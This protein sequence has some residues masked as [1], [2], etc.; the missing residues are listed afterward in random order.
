MDEENLDILDK[1]PFLSYI[2]YN[3]DSYLGIIGNSDDQITT[4]YIFS[5]IDD[6]EMKHLFLAL[7]DEWWWETNREL[8]INIA[9]NYK[10]TVFSDTKKTFNTKVLKVEKGPNITL[11]NIIA[12]RIKRKQINLIKKM[13]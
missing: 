12:K 5:E 8:P 11:D 4:V 10:W 1:F 2:T 3:D 6:E 13:D 7:G 9:L